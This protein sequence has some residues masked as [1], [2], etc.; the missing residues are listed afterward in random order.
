VIRLLA[1]LLAP[2]VVIAGLLFGLPGHQGPHLQKVDSVQGEAPAALGAAVDQADAQ[3]E[4]QAERQATAR[5]RTA[6]RAVRSSIRPAVATA[7]GQATETLPLQVT[8]DALSTAVVP[9]KRAVIVSGEVVNDSFDT[10]SDINVYAC[11]SGT[12]ITTA[13]DLRHA[14][15]ATT[16][17]VVC[18]RTSVF[19]TIDELAPGDSATYRLKVP[20]DRLGIGS[21]PGAYWFGVQALGT[22]T[23]GRDAVADGTVRTFLPQVGTGEDRPAGRSSFTVVLPF[24]GRTL[25]TSDGR[26]A[27]AAEWRKSLAPGG[28]LANLLALAEDAPNDGAAL[29][30]DPAVI[31]AVQQIAAG[32]PERTL[33]TPIPEKG[34]ESPSP[35]PSPTAQAEDE[36]KDAPKPDAHAAAWLQRFTAVAEHLPV[37]ALPYGDLDVA[38]AARHDSKALQ[39]ARQ[40]SDA[41][42]SDLGLTST[43]VIASPNGYLPAEAREVAGGATL[44]ASSDALPAELAEG[45]EIPAEVTIG[46]QDV[47]ISEAGV[48]AGGPAPTTGTE[49]LALRQRLLAEGLV[50]SDEASSTLVVL[51]WDTDP[52]PDPSGFFDELDRP[53]VET[54]GTLPTSPDAVEVPDLVYPTSQLDRELP[55]TQFDSADHLTELGDTLDRL[56]AEDDGVATVAT[57][58]AL[59]DTSYLTRDAALAAAGLR[60]DARRS[61]EGATD[62][63]ADQLARVDVSVP[64]FVILGSTEGPFAMTVANGLERPIRLGVRATTSGGLDIRAPKSIKVPAGSSRTVNLVAHT[65]EPGVHTLVLVVTDAEGHPVRKSQD[66]SI[67]SRDVGWVIWLIMGGGGAL[68]FV[69]IVLRWRKRLRASRSGAALA[70]AATAVVIATPGVDTA[71]EPEAPEAP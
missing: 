63:Y 49:A 69:A 1:A 2:L 66:I 58:E 4:A 51:P 3:T 67:R 57:R 36:G 10:W 62:W 20:R 27:A 22:S 50:R 59:S 6:S 37:L 30:V 45:D 31:A 15:E 25:H 13:H 52:G 65:T 24:R 46:S 18:G 28:R 68:L 47:H 40:E 53:F 9:R 61:L 16:D 33:G 48:A 17:D 71:V 5:S 19:V 14:A 32:N 8:M 43:P 42:F 12:P 54:T 7:D 34:E 23:E 64:N 56:L 44:I 29:L 41:V 11:S 38:G 21:H 70:A 55:R 26:L 39:R 35:S 60:G